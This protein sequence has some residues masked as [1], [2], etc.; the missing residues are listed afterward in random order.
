[1][2]NKITRTDWIQLVIWSRDRVLS[3][4]NL[5]EVVTRRGMLIANLTWGYDAATGVLICQCKRSKLQ[6][7]E[8]LVNE[9]IAAYG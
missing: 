2:R 7:L 5:C 6:P 3:A 4:T 1:M 8:C 9:F